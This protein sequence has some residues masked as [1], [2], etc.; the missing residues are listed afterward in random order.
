MSKKLEEKLKEVLENTDDSYASAFVDENGITVCKQVKDDKKLDVEMTGVNLFSIVKDLNKIEKLKGLII[1]FS[2]NIC[3]VQTLKG[4]GFIF[5]IMKQ[6]A[7]IG[8]AKYE[9]H[10]M[11]DN[12]LE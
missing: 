8:R 6:E 1:T 7:N 12:F 10:K 2:K 5:L 9:L 3:V 11:K 4:G